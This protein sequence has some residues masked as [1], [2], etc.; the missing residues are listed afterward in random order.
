M[1]DDFINEER[2]ARSI[3]RGK[4]KINSW[5]KVKIRQ[6]LKQNGITDKLISMAF[7]EINEADYLNKIEVLL[8]K[9]MLC[10]TKESEPVRSHKTTQ[11]LIQKAMNT[12]WSWSFQPIKITGH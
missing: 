9:N 10:C 6:S 3:V 12:I 8:K 11:H 4:F 1:R 7:A 2:Y 5:G